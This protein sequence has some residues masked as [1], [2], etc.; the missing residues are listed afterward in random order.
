MAFKMAAWAK[1]LSMADGHHALPNALSGIEIGPVARYELRS[2]NFMLGARSMT[3][4]LS[5]RANPLLRP[6]KLIGWSSINTR[7]RS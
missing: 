5:I 6:A 7:W 2:L 1:R 3:K 4:G